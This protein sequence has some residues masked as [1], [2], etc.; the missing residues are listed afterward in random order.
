MPRDR[1]IEPIAPTTIPGDVT[2]PKIPPEMNPESDDRIQEPEEE[3]Q[4][5]LTEVAFERSIS[6]LPPG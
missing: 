5:R 1:T 2:D 4:A 3:E 6:R